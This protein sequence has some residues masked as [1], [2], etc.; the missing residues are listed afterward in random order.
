MFESGINQLEY[1]ML[2][3]SIVC[4]ARLCVT[5]RLRVLRLAYTD[6]AISP[7][8]QQLFEE[9]VLHCVCVER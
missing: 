4:A 2:Q 6:T 9:N 7:H 1:S 3:K 5:E 8:R